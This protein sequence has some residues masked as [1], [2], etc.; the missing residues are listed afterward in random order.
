[1]RGQFGADV[2]GQGGQEVDGHEHGVAAGAG[3]DFSGPAHDAGDAFAALP[4]GAFAFAEGAGG[5]A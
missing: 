1:M 5:A 2:F 3:G 4:G